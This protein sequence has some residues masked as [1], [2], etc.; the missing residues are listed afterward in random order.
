MDTGQAEYSH[1]LPYLYQTEKQVYKLII[2]QS[3]AFEINKNQLFRLK[4]CKISSENIHTSE[5][6]ITFAVKY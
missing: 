6:F 4:I 3:T 1:I 2:L 5:F